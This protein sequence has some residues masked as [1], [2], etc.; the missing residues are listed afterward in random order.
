MT[1]QSDP[2]VR[3]EILAVAY[4]VSLNSIAR[5]RNAGQVP[6]PDAT[7]TTV[8]V[9]QPAVAWRLATLRAW[10]PGIADRCAALLRTIESFPPSAA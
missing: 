8:R 10:R 2:A 9:R 6:L 4:D 7:Y 5:A 1:V 3:A